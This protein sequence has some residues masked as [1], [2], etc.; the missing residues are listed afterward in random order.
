MKRE[1]FGFPRGT[2]SAAHCAA[3]SRVTTPLADSKGFTLMEIVLVLI[4][5][6]LTASLVIPRVG[7]GWKRME[8]REFLQEFTQTLR[9]SR[10][11]A[12]NSNQVVAFRINGEE[13]AYDMKRP[14]SR[15]IPQN[16]DIMAGGLER[17]PDTGDF[18]IL[19]YP[20]GSMTGTDLE[21][22]FDQERTFRLHIHPLFGTV[23][24]A[25]AGPG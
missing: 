16:V 13:R 23:E 1:T 20:D 25:R 19:F 11:Y 18:V 12:M 7:A 4:I 22:V 17:D 3:T 6:A 10:L 15:R 9:S 2:K 24:V 21:I 5:L 8:D 14:L